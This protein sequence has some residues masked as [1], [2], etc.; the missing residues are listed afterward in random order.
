MSFD[1][2][3]YTFARKMEKKDEGKR[4][5]SPYNIIWVGD[6]YYLVCKYPKYESLS[7]LRLEKINNITILDE[8]AEPVASIAGFENGFDIAEY[9]NR[10]I[11]MFSG[12]EERIELKC[13][14][15]ILQAMQD[16]FGEELKI[17]KQ[18]EDWF[19]VSVRTVRQGMLYF[20]LQMA[21]GV[22]VLTPADF[23]QEVAQMLQKI[24]NKYSPA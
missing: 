18:E 9:A 19:W 24:L 23:R 6:Y 5:V 2:L 21:D 10:H 4:V 16:R 3:K 12:K 1:Y 11:H 7:N 8:S 13:R 15:D 17:K 20:V 14:G 22:E